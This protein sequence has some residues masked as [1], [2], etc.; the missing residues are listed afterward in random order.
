M[1]KYKYL[2]AKA[3]A[4]RT[5]RCCTSLVLFYPTASLLGRLAMSA[6]TFS[7]RPLIFATA[8]SFVPSAATKEWP[9]P[10]EAGAVAVIANVAAA[11]GQDFQRR[12]RQ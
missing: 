6:L 12:K 5:Q 4:S 1:H 2:A 10:G 11:G 3:Q 9:S 8:A 7:R